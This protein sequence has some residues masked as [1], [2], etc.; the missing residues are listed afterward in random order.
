MF[1]TSTVASSTSIPMARARPPS[2]IRFSV[3]PKRKRPTSPTRMASG[4]LVPTS[5]APRQLPRKKRIIK[6]TRIEAITASCS[7][8]VTAARTK[9]DWSKSSFSSIPSGAAALMMGS[10][11]RV[12]STTARVEA[13]AFLRMARYVA[14]RPLTRTRL[15]CTAYPSRTRA[16]SPST[17]VAP[18][19]A[20]MGRSLKALIESGLELSFTS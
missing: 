15:S 3:W 10:W 14:R 18:S 13:S 9:S 8:L 16:T 1:S 19:T 11:S 20:L 4:M 6:E 2:V 5:T 7:T 17:T 12:P